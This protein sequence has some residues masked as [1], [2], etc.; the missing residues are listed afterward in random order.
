MPPEQGVW[1]HDQQCL[2]PGPNKPGQ[3]NE[4]D[5]IGFC[6]C[7]PFHL[8]PE[9]DELLAEKGVFGHQF[10]VA[11]AQVSQSLQRQGGCERFGPASQARGERIQAT[12]L[13]PL[14][15]GENTCHT[16]N[17]SIT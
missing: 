9:N 16:R 17:F 5:A 6:A 2:L 10:R 14:E 7:R 11:S 15:S 12:R 13:Q 1:L 3:Q 8:S 4:K